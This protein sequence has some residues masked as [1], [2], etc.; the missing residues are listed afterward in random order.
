MPGAT[1]C[2]KVRTSASIRPILAALDASAYKHEMFITHPFT[3]F[4]ALLFTLV[5]V[6]PGAHGD[7]CADHL[8]IGIEDPVT[9]V[10]LATQNLKS[11]LDFEDYAQ[12]HPKNY[13]RRSDFM[14]RQLDRLGVRYRRRR[15]WWGESNEICLEPEGRARFN[16]IARRI[17]ESRGTTL[18]YNPRKTS[19]MGRGG[20]LGYY[21]PQT[22]KIGLTDLSMLLG[23]PDGVLLHELKHVGLES[24]RSRMAQVF[25]GLFLRWPFARAQSRS[26][27]YD[28]LLNSEEA[29]TWIFDWKLARRYVKSVLKNPR[30]DLAD[31]ILILEK[32]MDDTVAVLRDLQTMEER[33]QSFA[34]WRWTTVDRLGHVNFWRIDLFRSVSSTR[35]PEALVKMAMG[36][37]SSPSQKEARSFFRSEQGRLRA[38]EIE[39]EARRQRLKFID[40]SMNELTI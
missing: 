1:A 29:L 30:I 38:I 24:R 35:L 2:N 31:Y 8:R 33:A 9:V 23:R 27:I 16:V 6:A 26:G 20:Q 37:S 22:R 14:A 10:E 36:A 11:A 5:F 13:A 4:A 17:F 28:I 21:N 18:C 7:A 39:A 19:F 15:T 34:G 12:I 25:E 40:S 32:Q 3:T